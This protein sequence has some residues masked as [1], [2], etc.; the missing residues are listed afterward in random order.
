M[1]TGVKPK[2]AQRV[3]T[4][5]QAPIVVR[6]VVTRHGA[7]EILSTKFDIGW[8][9]S[10]VSTPALRAFHSLAKVTHLSGDDL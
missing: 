6:A 5:V 10:S 4:C 9:F 3:R 8:R 7:P 2:R 1:S